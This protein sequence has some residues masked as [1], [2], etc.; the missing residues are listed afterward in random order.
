MGS[1]HFLTQYKHDH[2]SIFSCFVLLSG[3][4]LNSCSCGGDGLLERAFISLYSHKIKKR[5]CATLLTFRFHTQNICIYGD[6]IS[7]RHAR[8]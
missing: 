8:F 7:K 6:F 5:L 2:I 1:N 3:M 4:T